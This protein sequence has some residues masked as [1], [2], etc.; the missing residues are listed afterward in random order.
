MK[1]GKN[2]DVKEK[3][4]HIV[5]ATFSYSEDTLKGLRVWVSPIREL[6]KAST[7]NPNILLSYTSR[8]LHRKV[9]KKKLNLLGEER[10][11]QMESLQAVFKRQLS[12]S[13][14]IHY[15]LHQLHTSRPSGDHEEAVTRNHPLLSITLQ[16]D[17]EEA[18]GTGRWLERGQTLE[19]LDLGFEMST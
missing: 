4:V 2:R 12:V 14:L 19:R 18:S 6:S 17:R 5:L 8:T 16:H 3:A 13:T 10:R 9:P 7:N 11:F 1:E 15:S